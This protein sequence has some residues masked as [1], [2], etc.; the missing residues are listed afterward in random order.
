MKHVKPILNV[1]SV[2]T[3]L[4]L[5]SIR[6]CVCVCVCV[7]FNVHVYVHLMRRQTLRHG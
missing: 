1:Q 6:A 7:C 4:S 2:K 5:S 3:N